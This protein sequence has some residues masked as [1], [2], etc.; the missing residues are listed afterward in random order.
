MTKPDDDPKRRR[1]DPFDDLMRGMGI[2][3]STF[4]RLFDDMQRALGKMLEEGGFEPGKPYMHGFNFKI[5]PD[6][7]PHISEFGNRPRAGANP[8]S[9]SEER[10]P[11]TDVIETDKDVALTLEMPGVEKSDIDL[12]VTENRVEISV[13]TESRK[14][15]KAVDLPTKVKPDTT[16]AT[17][18]NGVLDV[19]ILKK[20]PGKGEDG[21]RVAVE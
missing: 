5:G 3:P 19:V 14:Y 8:V 9:L 1:N 18:K 10:E 13:D 17:Y 2:D 20:E 16:K 15:H 21:L 11:P 4:E 12:R 6:G 7:K